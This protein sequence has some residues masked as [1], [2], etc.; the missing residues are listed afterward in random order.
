MIS[1]TPT[2]DNSFNPTALSVPFI[3]LTFCDVA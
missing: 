2:P 1:A 3:N